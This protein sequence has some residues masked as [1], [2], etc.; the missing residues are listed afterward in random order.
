M[1]AGNVGYSDTRSF[2][3]S[4]LGDIA[5]AIRNRTKNAALMARQERAYAEEQAEKQGTSLEEAKIGKGYFFRRALGSTFGG[6]RIA[7]TRGLFEKDPP[8][9]R[10]PLGSIE[11]RFRGG[12]DYGLEQADTPKTVT[13]TPSR[14]RGTATPTGTV[15]ESKKD[16]VP[17]EKNPLQVTNTRLTV[18]MLSTFQRLEK[19]LANI[20]SFVGSGSGSPQA[21][22]ALENQKML[23]G[24]VFTKTTNIINSINKAV[25]GQTDTIKKVAKEEAQKL[26][27]DAIDAA[28]R[29]EELGSEGQNAKAG[30]MFAKALDKAK[31]A[32]SIMS[33]PGS[34]LKDIFGP[35]SGMAKGLRNPKAAMRL[36]RMR[37]KR[38]FGKRFAR[39]ITGRPFGRVG[40]IIAKNTLK[41]TAGKV[42]VK[43]VGKMAL[44]KVPILGAVAGVAFGIER[45]MKGDWLGAI[46]EVASGT[47]SIFPGVGTA[48]STGIDAA[49]IAKDVNEAMNQETPAFYEGGVIKGD[50]WFSSK[51]SRFENEKLKR[52]MGAK[53]LDMNF[54]REWHTLQLRFDKK[55]RPE[56]LNRIADGLDAYFFKKGG[57]Q[58]FTDGLKLVFSKISSYLKNLPG[59]V[60]NF[61]RNRWSDLTSGL[62]TLS[63]LGS[64]RGPQ[65]TATGGA[66]VTQANISRGFG[67]RDGLGS[68]SRAGGH[69]GLDIAGPGFTQGTAIS[70]LPKGKVIDVGIMGDSNDPGGPGGNNA[71]YGNFV[72]IK[73]DTGEIVKMAHFD[74][75]SVSKGDMVGK[76]DDGTAKVIGKLGNTGLS[77][78]PHLHLDLGTGYNAGSAY[79]SGLMDPMPF[80]NDLI[81]GG[82]NVKIEGETARPKAET[83]PTATGLGKQGTMGNKNFGSTSGEGKTGILIVPGH[84]SGGGAPG[85]K[86]LVKK[87]ARNAYDNIKKKYP[88]A[89]VQ[90]Q[91]LDSMFEDTDAGFNKQKEWY[92]K[93]E[94]EGWEVLEIHM[95]ASMESG[96]GKGRGVIVPVGELNRIEKHYAQNYGAFDRGFRDLAAPNRG[97]SIF[98]LGN[99]SPELQQATKSGQVTKAQLDALTASFEDSV[100]KGMGLVP[101]PAP[102]PPASASDEAKKQAVWNIFL[103]GLQ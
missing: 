54:W 98:E 37:A 23:L 34:R 30:N 63:G 14:S 62:R 5:T 1:A 28:A 32:Q 39:G 87:L 45:A 18:G 86:E 44:K 61:F 94:A 41:K 91:D 73:T 74:S 70:F 81:R 19:Q 67:V 66:K 90:M 78:G 68:G 85:E 51:I 52:D 97:V 8:M 59:R 60:G 103:K 88:N 11:S 102:T 76:Q 80:V 36:A 16:G 40:K 50:D 101:T 21:V 7:R 43:G 42:A 47:A 2:S 83:A 6:D 15:G 35:A 46:G 99:M 64:Y 89:N 82:G 22:Y 20:N 27:Q 96:F 3:G 12:F 4:L 25:G 79:V 69:T 100:T 13:S 9:G 55:N 77:T 38:V 75:V 92:K 58:A 95:D 57:V 84:A 53:P 49:L 71:G 48:I 72:V 56:I 24:S 93:K 10:D 17:T 33:A 29:T 65:M 26:K 31:K